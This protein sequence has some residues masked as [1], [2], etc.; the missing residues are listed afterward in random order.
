MKTIIAG[1]PYYILIATFLISLW[2]SFQ[3]FR[4][5]K[6]AKIHHQYG[7]KLSACHNKVFDAPPTLKYQPLST[8]PRRMHL[9]YINDKSPSRIIKTKRGCE[10]KLKRMTESEKYIRKSA[11][12]SYET[13][14]PTIS[15]L[16]RPNRM[17][18]IGK[19]NLVLVPSER[20]LIN[21]KADG[22]LNEQQ[23]LKV[24]SAAG[25]RL[26]NNHCNK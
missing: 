3:W 14:R 4:P 11:L 2:K 16:L 7:D 15:S 12:S 23:K 24:V 21:G 13:T 9:S 18:E 19:C 25:N 26:E 6:L 17:V 5:K 8:V 1:I 20:Y 10:I 22:G